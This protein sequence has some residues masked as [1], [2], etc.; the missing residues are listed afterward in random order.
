MLL[1][2]LYLLKSCLFSCLSAAY[3]QLTIV[4]ST[5]R[6]L[7]RLVIQHV[8][9]N[10]ISHLFVTQQRLNNRH[11]AKKYKTR[12]IYIFAFFIEVLSQQQI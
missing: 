5:M 1:L 9:Q 10:D 3:I 7:I 12:Y 11:E 8:T 4:Q 2:Y 6:C